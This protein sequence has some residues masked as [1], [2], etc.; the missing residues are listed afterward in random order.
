M[1]FGS[2]AHSLLLESSAAPIVVIDPAQ[3]RSKPTKANPEGN[4]PKGWSNDAI[5]EARD[6]A[7]ADGKHPLLPED[8]ADISEMVKVA[9]AYIE[10]LRHSEPAIWNAFQPDGG[11]RE[12]TMV[13]DEGGILCKLRTDLISNDYT[14]VVD[15]KTTAGSVEPDNFAR[16]ALVG[17]GYAFG[18]A[19]YQ[20]GIKALA[21]EDAA[22]VHLAQE[23]ERPFLCS[24]IGMDPSW[25]AYGAGKVAAA[26]RMWQQC[27]RTG[28]WPGYPARVTY[29][30]LP[31]WESARFEAKLIGIPYE[32][33]ALFE[34]TDHV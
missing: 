34:R 11:Q 4:I 25:C 26:L 6:A 14:I 23:V 29:P 33:G 19:W 1:Y 20:R 7:R 8:F 22:F 16:S 3:H 12:T 17:Q 2:A 21:G 5:K 13:W 18:A 15:Y 24:L 10:S 9:A 30:E 31:A 32:L 28:E 27:L